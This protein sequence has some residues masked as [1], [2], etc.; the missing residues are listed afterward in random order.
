MVPL[1]Y[2]VAGVLVDLLLALFPPLTR[3]GRAVTVVGVAAMLATVVAPG[4]PTLGQ[5]RPHVP[6]PVPPLLAAIGFGALA[7][8]LGW[9]IGGRLLRYTTPRRT[10]V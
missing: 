4:F 2:L 5:H 3:S 10:R 6:W 9:S 8:A 7:A 1:A